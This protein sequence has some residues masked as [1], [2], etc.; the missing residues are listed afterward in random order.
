[1]VVRDAIPPQGRTDR[2]A[3]P[4]YPR[5]VRELILR[6]GTNGPPKGA[7]LRSGHAATSA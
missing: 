1:M 3:V 2:L 5:A 4:F 7:S 6:F